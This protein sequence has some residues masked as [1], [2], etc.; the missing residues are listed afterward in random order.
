MMSRGPEIR[1]I[2]ESTTISVIECLGAA[3][4]LT[5]GVTLRN[6]RCKK[7]DLGSFSFGFTSTVRGDGSS[8]SSLVL[9]APFSKSPNLSESGMLRDVSLI[10]ASPHRAGAPSSSSIVQSRDTR[11]SCRPEDPQ[12]RGGFAAARHVSQLQ[13]Y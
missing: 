9:A 1:K 2:M 5:C 3:C 11:K 13:V 4:C 12:A 6:W 10:F 7:L 8:V